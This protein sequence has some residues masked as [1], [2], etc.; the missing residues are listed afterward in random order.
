[1]PDESRIIDQLVRLETKIDKMADEVHSSNSAVIKLEAWK[2]D[3]V[4]PALKALSSKVE[5]QQGFNWKLIGGG[6]AIA[7]LGGGLGQGIAKLLS[8]G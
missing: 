8:G 1:M 6:T 3:V 5:A 7:L 4:S 2:D